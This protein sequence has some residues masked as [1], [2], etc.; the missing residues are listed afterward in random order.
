MLRQ[1]SASVA[2]LALL[3]AGAVN[4]QA[5]G[6]AKIRIGVDGNYSPFSKLTPEGKLEGFDIDI[7]QALCAQMKA[8]CTLVRQEWDG[9]IPALNARKFDLIVASMS[10]T[11][12]R[13]LKVDFS[14]SYYDIKS[15]FVAKKGSVTDV[16][17]A[18]LKGKKI[19][20]LRNSPRAKYVQDNYPGNQVLLVA[21]EAD[22]TMELAA[23]RGDIALVS[24]LAA[25]PAFL[26][27]PEGANFAKVGPLICPSGCNTS[28]G[29]GIAMRK[30]E[31]ALRLKVNA[32]L[33]AI[34]DNGTYKK[35]ND[36]Y[37]DVS[38]RGL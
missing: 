8:E 13:Q 32:A 11:P 14:D 27:A 7:A 34:T 35:I 29:N 21:K 20:A 4:A 37:F 33:K 36:K 1:L 25:T 6:W 31:E 9:M 2:L 24:L 19:I 22:A 12:E 16:S 28:G 18:A 3:A 23:G 30:G 38:I 26:K 15:T 5:P 17:P 10:I